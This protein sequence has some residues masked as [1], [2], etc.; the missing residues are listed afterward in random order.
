LIAL[1]I[2]RN[3]SSIRKAHGVI[4]LQKTEIEKQK[5]IV[6]EKQKEILDSIHYAKRIQ[7]ALLTSQNYFKKY[8]ADFFVL[9]K[10][11]DIVSGDFYWALHHKG[12]FFLATADCT[13]HGVPGAFMSLLNISFFNETVIEKK[14]TQPDAVLNEMR[15]AIIRTLNPEGNEQAKDGMD[16]VLYAIDAKNKE[17]E[18]AAANNS[19]YIARKGELI[20]CPADKMPVGAYS[21]NA[22]PFTL[23]KQALE[24]GDIIYSFTDG[25]ADQFGGPKGKKFKYKQLEELLRKIAAK[26]MQEQKNILEQ[27]IDEWKKGFE[28]VDDILVIGIKV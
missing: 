28:Q 4:S 2:Y 18:Y 8:T 22:K 21:E 6:E 15:E 13:G 9:Y 17:M 1:I 25:Y 23:R 19:F 11:K 10:P 27:T 3:Y 12:K 16:C 26:P 24:E 7:S 14:I 20:T 5:E